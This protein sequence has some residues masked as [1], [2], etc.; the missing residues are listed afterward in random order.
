LLAAGIGAYSATT[1]A[2][3]SAACPVIEA[4]EAEETAAK[5]S[6]IAIK[7]LTN[8]IPAPSLAP[9]CHARPCCVAQNTPDLPSRL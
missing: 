7:T 3:A 1:P 6:A 9:T 8:F 4:A 5:D 2:R